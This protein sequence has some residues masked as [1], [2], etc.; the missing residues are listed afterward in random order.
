MNVRLDYNSKN[1]RFHTDRH[2]RGVVSKPY[3]ALSPSIPLDVALAFT[4]YA[5]FKLNTMQKTPP[6]L[7]IRK[8][9]KLFLNGKNKRVPR[10]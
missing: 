8:E 9:F 4:E 3:E 5:Y 1:G 2:P 7:N 6:T 10:L